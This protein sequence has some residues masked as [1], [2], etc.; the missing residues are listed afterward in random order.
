M[1]KLVLLAVL[2]GVAPL[3]VWS[4][5]AELA[6]GAFL[7]AGRDLQ[8]PNFSETVILLLH[9]D[10]DQGAMGL[11]INRRTELTLGRVFED[12]KEAKGRT[13]CAY[14]GGPVEQTNVLALLR[15]S[16]EPDNAERIFSSVYLLTSK[17][18]LQKTLSEKADASVFH[19]YLG[20]AGW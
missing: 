13:D 19:V 14:M 12:F 1:A 17:D 15:T 7:V 10:E 2:C 4:Q 6:A 18:V 11:V 8:D 3:S 16:V 9:Y 20:Y 5:E